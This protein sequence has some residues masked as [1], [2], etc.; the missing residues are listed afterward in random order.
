ME[1]FNPPPLGSYGEAGHEICEIHEPEPNEGLFG[2]DVA[3]DP[4]GSAGGGW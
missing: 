1:I 3:A 2:G 4:A